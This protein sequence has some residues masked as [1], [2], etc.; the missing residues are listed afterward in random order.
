MH[1]ELYREHIKINFVEIQG[2]SEKP[3]CIEIKIN[4]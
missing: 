1:R 4:K 3:G 2:A